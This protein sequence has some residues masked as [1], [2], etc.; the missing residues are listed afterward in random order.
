MMATFEMFETEAEREEREA[1]TA[2]VLELGTMSW[3]EVEALALEEQ[4]ERDGNRCCGDSW[5]AAMNL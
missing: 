3:E 1:T 2:G 4:I 5:V